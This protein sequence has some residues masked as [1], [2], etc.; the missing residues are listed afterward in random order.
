MSFAELVKITRT[1]NGLTLRSFCK[2]FG[3]DPAYISRIETGKLSAPT[4][5]DKLN[6]LAIALGFK[7]GSS[8]WVTFFDLAYESRSELPTDVKNNAPEVF[9]LLPAF[10]RTPDN[11]KISKEKVKELL[12]FLINGKQSK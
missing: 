9:S 7:R 11:K 6:G 12:D 8:D 3:Y 4:D 1:K 10:L 5:E 2:R